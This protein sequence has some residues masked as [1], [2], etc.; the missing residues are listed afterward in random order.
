M[1]ISIV[2]REDIVTV[3]NDL[4]DRFT[5]RLY[6]DAI[7]MDNPGNPAYDVCNS[8]TRL[9][10]C[11]LIW[12]SRIP[13]WIPLVNR[14]L[15]ESLFATTVFLETLTVAI[16]YLLFAFRLSNEGDLHTCPASIDTNC[17]TGDESGRVRSQEGDD[18]D[19]V[20]F[21]APTTERRASNNVAA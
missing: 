4:A 2:A 7:F 19:N 8:L 13:F 20:R 18:S 21:L 17:L 15:A 12:R 16:C 14:R 3:K 9:A 5:F 11:S 10:A 6:V 1:G